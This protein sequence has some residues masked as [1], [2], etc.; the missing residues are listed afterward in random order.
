MI[1][2]ARHREWFEKAG[3]DPDWA[4]EYGCFTAEKVADLPDEWR[5]GI[6]H[7]LPGVLLPWVGPDGF[8]SPQLRPDDRGL[9]EAGEPGP[10]YLFQKD[11]RPVLWALRVNGAKK[12][13]IVE[14]TKQA[15]LAAKI[16][17]LEYDVYGVAG[18]TAWSKDQMPILDLQVTLGREVVVCFD[19]DAA[20]NIQVY[21][22]SIKFQ[23]ALE[24]EGATKISWIRIPAGGT[25]GLDD[26]MKGR[27]HEHKVAYMTTLIEKAKAKIADKPPRVKKKDI[28]ASEDRPLLDV[29]DDRLLVMNRITARLIKRWDGVRLFSHGEVLSEYVTDKGK[30]PRLRALTQA[31]F[32]KQIQ[33]VATTV[34]MAADGSA[35]YT[36]PDPQTMK[37]CLEADVYSYTQVDQLVRIP[38]L[39]KDGS[40]CQDEGYDKASRT[41]LVLNGL[42]VNVPDVPTLE[43]VAAA[44]ALLQDEWLGDFPFPDDGSAANMLALVLTPFIRSRVSVVPVAVLDGRQEG[45]GKGLI[46][47]ILAILILGQLANPRGFTPDDN[48]NRKA[49]LPVFE[50][51]TPLAFF[52][53]AHRIHGDNFSRAITAPIY[54]DRVLGVSKVPEYLNQLTMVCAGNNVELVGDLSRRVYAIGVKPEGENPQD[55]DTSIY[56]HPALRQWTWD[57]RSALVTACL[58]LIRH[59]TAR[60]EPSGQRDMATFEDW[61]ETIGGILGLAGI[62]GFL[63]NRKAWRVEND[64]HRQH[65]IEHFDFLHF[66]YEGEPFTVAQVREAA[67][68]AGQSYAAPPGKDLGRPADPNINYGRELGQAY[69]RQREKW[70]GGY[71][72]HKGGTAHNS[73]RTWW[74]ERKSPDSDTSGGSGNIP[75]AHLMETEST[76]SHENPRG[77]EGGM[78]PDPPDVPQPL[79]FDL[80]T[81]SATE[82]YSRSDFIRLGGWTTDGNQV[83]FAEDVAGFCNLMGAMDGAG[84]IIG[85]NIMGFDLQA[86]ARGRNVDIRKLAMDEKV[87][88]TLLAQRYYDPPMAKEKKYDFDRAANL[89]AL[90]KRYELG[91]KSADLA[92]L[93]KEYDGYDKIPIDLPIYREYL[94]NDVTLNWRLYQHLRTLIPD[95]TYLMREH[96]VAALAAQFSLNGFKVDEVLLTERFREGEVRQQAA[97]KI[98]HEKFGLPIHDKKGMVHKSPLATTA[99]KAHLIKLLEERGVTGYWTTGKTEAIA[100][101]REAMEQLALQHMDKPEVRE[102]CRLVIIVVTTRTIYKTIQQHMIGDRVHTS[103]SMNQST[104]RWSSKNPGLTVMGKRGGKW[105]EREVFVAEPGEVVIAC[106]LAQIDMRAIAGLSQDAA[107]IDMLG[108]ED[109]HA[110]IARMLFGDPAKR[111]IAKP[112]GHGWNYGRGIRA[113]A[114]DNDIDPKLVRQFDRESRERFPRLVEWQEEVRVIAGSGEL[115]DNGFGRRMRP[116]PSRAHTQGPALMGQGAARDLMMES[117]LRLPEE[118]WPMLRAQVHDEVVLSVP[119]DDAVDIQRAVLNAM[120]FE[121]RGVPIRGDGGPTDRTSWGQVY[122]K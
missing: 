107:Y 110:E 121:W 58:T 95:E 80:E 108:H 24:A 22:A 96:K 78:F 34:R 81:C 69:N 98:L 70:I 122:A 93:A 62:G 100:T 106:D 18:C 16:V 17:P 8:V 19:A 88:D 52:D 105:R 12:I 50:S 39:R 13:L 83:H 40:V 45:V 31:L 14:G 102:I 30:P 119:K 111:E 103:I 64:Y 77:S 75:P 2:A 46:L 117:L 21:N 67:V 115:L 35:Q 109:P 85:H 9:D 10:K 1:L 15:L 5:K 54:S 61:Q 92:A 29:D 36:W 114:E 53:E 89:D 6:G 63:E 42:T 104:G 25:N 99:G 38:F 48:E 51:G 120:T 97:L 57:N 33:T 91:A 28:T 112:I 41:L 66:Q 101:S 37:T 44:V 76:P 32:A 118:C 11:S 59:W 116:E 60:G 74:L 72:L 43:Q 82:L 27:D 73:V 71:R 26:V 55:R 94:A 47:D 68:R 20:Q 3:I 113:I 90:G 84:R 65:W 4:E 7:A 49:L 86:L 56:K 23:A 87:Y 79:V